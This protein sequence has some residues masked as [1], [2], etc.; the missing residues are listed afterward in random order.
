M[1]QNSHFPTT[2]VHP[3]AL[4]YII[5]DID[6]VFAKRQANCCSWSNAVHLCS[7]SLAVLEK[8]LYD[9]CMR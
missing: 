6:V 7:G 9:E 5:Y 4:A 8:Q 3:N 2:L 1:S